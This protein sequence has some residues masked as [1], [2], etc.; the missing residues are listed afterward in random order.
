MAQVTY[1]TSEYFPVA[2]GFDD[3]LDQCQ[4]INASD[5]KRLQEQALKNLIQHACNTTSYYQQ[6]LSGLIDHEGNVDLSGWGDVP[7]LTRRDI[8]DHFAELKSSHCPSQH[9]EVREVRSSGSTAEP[10]KVLTTSFADIASLAGNAR[11]LSWASVDYSLNMAQIIPTP[12][13]E[14]P[15]PGTV[16]EDSWAP[17][18]Y[19]SK[20]TSKQYKLDILPRM[21]FNSI[22]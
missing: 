16:S 3:L 1:T 2:Q 6:T 22:G 8:Q 19:P 14:A 7:L 20:P 18:W 15:F 17:F 11:G 21:M 12:D 10:L 13:G 5:L 4:W 9:G